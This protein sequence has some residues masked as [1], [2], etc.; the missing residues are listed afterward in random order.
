MPRRRRVLASS[1]FRRGVN[2]RSSTCAK[3][4][5]FGNCFAP[6]SHRPTFIRRFAGIPRRVPA[7]RLQALMPR[8]ADHQGASSK[9]WAER[10]AT[11]GGHYARG[12]DRGQIDALYFRVLW[13]R[14]TP[15]STSR[16]ETRA[17]RASLVSPVYQKSMGGNRK[18]ELRRTSPLRF[19]SAKHLLSESWPFPVAT[20]VDMCPPM[21][22]RPAA[23]LGA[24]PSGGWGEL[25]LERH[26]QTV[27]PTK[28]ATH[29]ERAAPWEQERSAR[30]QSRVSGTQGVEWEWVSS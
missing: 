9:Y 20:N 18:M 22:R 2:T 10:R 8:D 30:M 23:D 28:L 5:Y 17:I 29:A 12:V 15:S 4:F 7:L 14:N 21:L 26:E 11:N 13:S 27:K 24:T 6:G 16:M 19:T 25:A 3:Q 1:S